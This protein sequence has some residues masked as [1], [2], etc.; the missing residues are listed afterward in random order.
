MFAFSKNPLFAKNFLIR[1][2]TGLPI[3]LM[4]MPFSTAFVI[5]PQP[6]VDIFIWILPAGSL[7]RGGYQG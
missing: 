3:I 2:L 6:V 5:Y 7:G 4:N 1:V